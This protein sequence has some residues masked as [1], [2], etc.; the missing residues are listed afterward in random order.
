MGGKIHK[1]S[2]QEVMLSQINEEIK[3]L[4]TNGEGS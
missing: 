2:N 3:L 4:Y 1:N